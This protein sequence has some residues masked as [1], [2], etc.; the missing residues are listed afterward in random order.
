MMLGLVQGSR[1]CEGSAL[2]TLM[3]YFWKAG[4]QQY[5]T[6]Q[7]YGGLRFLY[8]NELKRTRGNERGAL[9]LFPL[10]M[11]STTLLLLQWNS[12][13]LPDN[14]GPQIVQL[15]T[16]GASYFAIM[17]IFCHSF[18]QAN[19]IHCDLNVAPQPQAP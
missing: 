19:C 12:T 5:L 11:E 8:Q 15:K 4:L 16:I 2:K 1:K 10:R 7:E 13:L 6:C 3:I 9:P 18:D 14:T 17:S